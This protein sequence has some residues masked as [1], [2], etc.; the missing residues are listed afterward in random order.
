MKE[1]EEEEEETEEGADASADEARGQETSERREG[2]RLG[3]V[4]VQGYVSVRN[5]YVRDGAAEAATPTTSQRV[6]LAPA[7]SVLHTPH[8]SRHHLSRHRQRHG[9][10]RTSSGRDGHERCAREPPSHM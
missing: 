3:V 2:L 9:Y 1:P 7:H 6:N 10:A 5:E 4:A 8:C